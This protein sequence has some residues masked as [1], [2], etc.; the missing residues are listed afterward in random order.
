MNENT[1]LYFSKY[2]PL[3]C[4]VLIDQIEVDYDQVISG[5]HQLFELGTA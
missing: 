3:T 5:R 4:V 1:Y 2:V